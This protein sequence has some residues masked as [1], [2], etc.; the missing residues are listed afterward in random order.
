MIMSSRNACLSLGRIFSTLLKQNV[1]VEI[2][3]FD[4]SPLEKE[5]RME[6]LLQITV[7]PGG[8]QGWKAALMEK[9]Q[10]VGI[11]ERGSQF[12]PC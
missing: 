8:V 9:R 1:K 2:I 12:L 11:G 7:F 3:L 6:K 10:Q 4:T 5:E